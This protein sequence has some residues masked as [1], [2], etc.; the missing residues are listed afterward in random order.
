[1][2]E[3]PEVGCAEGFES[4]PFVEGAG[5]GVAVDHVKAHL[6]EAKCGGMLGDGGQKCRAYALAAGLGCDEDAVHQERV[7]GKIAFEDGKKGPPPER[8]KPAVYA[9]KI[10]KS[11]TDE[12]T[13][14]GF[15]AGHAEEIAIAIHSADRMAWVEHAFDEAGG[16]GGGAKKAGEFRA[17]GGPEP[18][19][20][21]LAVRLSKPGFDGEPG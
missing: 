11:A 5:P 1:M 13:L 6:G 21:G 9:L 7:R 2:F 18:E 19:G 17:E 16:P 3:R 10:G 12:G 4:L 15:E 14:V 8:A 20:D